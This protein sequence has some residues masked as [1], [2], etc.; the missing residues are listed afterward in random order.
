M[1]EDYKSIEKLLKPAQAGDRAAREE[2]VKRNI[3]LVHYVVRRFRDRG[4]DYE[5]LFQCGCMGLLKAIDR[6]DPS[7]GARF[8]T[9]AVPLIMG[10][11]RRTL[12][13]DGMI[14][15][16]RTI[17]E[18]AVKVRK[19]REDYIARE[20]REPT[21]R[22]LSI[23]SGVTDEDALLALNAQA[24]V[25]SLDAPMSDSADVRLADTIRGGDMEDVE[26]RIALAQMLRALPERERTLIVR[27]YFCR[28]TQCEIARDMGISQVQ[29]SRMEHRILKDMQRQYDGNS[30]FTRQL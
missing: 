4:M 10:E 20:G 3:P 29:V 1:A 14:H 24:Q 30:D 8:S 6:F 15:V 13:D 22:E 28:R 2:L 25:R 5:D 7:F 16:S 17:R 9:Y 27:R 18:N 11:V 21:L 19:C 23:G 26:G 12:R